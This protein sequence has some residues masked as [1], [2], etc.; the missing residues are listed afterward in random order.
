MARWAGGK[1][2]EEGPK[3]RVRA[4]TA[5][6][7][8]DEDEDEVRWRVGSG[9]IG[10]LERSAIVACSKRLHPAN[11]SGPNEKQHRDPRQIPAF[12][13]ARREEGRGGEV[14]CSQVDSEVGRGDGRGDMRD[15]GAASEEEEGNVGTGAGARR[16]RNR[17]RGGAGQT[18][19]VPR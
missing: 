3:G 9:R 19:P 6:E 4:E 5:E 8:V 10:R 13:P 17:G 16:A 15:A 1:V 2:C 18:A 14:R 11:Q 12:H 7:E